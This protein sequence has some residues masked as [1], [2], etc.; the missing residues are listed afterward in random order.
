MYER[1]IVNAK[2]RL[3]HTGG[4]TGGLHP[5]FKRYGPRRRHQYAIKENGRI[6]GQ[7]Y[8]FARDHPTVSNRASVGANT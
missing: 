5:A 3:Q 8:L 2:R 4:K 1:G 6:A 7:V